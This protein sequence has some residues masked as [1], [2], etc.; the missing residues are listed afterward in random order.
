MIALPCIAHSEQK[1]QPQVCI[2][3]HL[4][5]AVGAHSHNKATANCVEDNAIMA[6]HSNVSEVRVGFLSSL[7]ACIVLL[8]LR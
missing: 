5:A 7:P 8:F 1:F 3:T 6:N 4:N 2:V